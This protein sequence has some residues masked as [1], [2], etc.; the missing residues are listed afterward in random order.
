MVIKH[1]DFRQIVSLT[2]V[3]ARW[4]E[5]LK[6][7]P[8]L[9]TKLDFS[10]AKASIP[11]ST[12]QKYLRFSKGDTTEVVWKFVAQE[13]RFLSQIP[14]ICRKLKSLRIENGFPT[15][16]LIKA[17]SIA[18]NLS[19]LIL[20]KNAGTTLD[21][22]S[23][24]LG[25]CSTLL[26]AEF[27]YIEA[28]VR[29]RRPSWPSNVLRLQALILELE[30][31]FS[32]HPMLCI[33]PLLELLPDIRELSLAH[34]SS[35]TTIPSPGK[36]E[37][38]QLQSLELINYRG[39]VSPQSLPSLR[40]LSLKDCREVFAFVHRL[41]FI[42]D[43]RESG[44]VRF[45]TPY[46]GLDAEMLLQLIGPKTEDLR[47]LDISHCA[48]LEECH[49]AK[50]VSMGYIDQIVGLDLSGLKVTDKIIEQLVPRAQ[51]LR[52]LKLASTSITGISVKALVT[53]PN[54]K[55]V[56]LD[57]RDCINVSPDAVALARK[58]VGLTVQCGPVRIRR[59]KKIR[60]E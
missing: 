8:S 46:A 50:I 16:S 54:N 1:L 24:I 27:Y 44:C 59:G 23:Q 6:S 37:M 9:W 22:V 4:Q 36:V 19:T 58:M 14:T 21:C 10:A 56:Y 38:G 55:L 34:W 53:E 40:F 43:L 45:S 35:S 52:I 5:Y 47:H 57:I 13:E 60:Y 2:R 49:L 12:I 17:V 7:I 48:S 26:R 11:K 41:G 32:L 39:K 3:S 20:S 31:V 33:D 28:S 18:D 42:P 29:I 51:R 15:V 30:E 25:R